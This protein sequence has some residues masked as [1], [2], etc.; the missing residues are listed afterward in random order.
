MARK[1]GLRLGRGSKLTKREIKAS[2]KLARK[3]EKHKNKIKEPY[4][5]ATHIVK[6]R[7][8]R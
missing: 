1:K 6:K 8:R 5:V 7:R 2:H 3:L 4:A